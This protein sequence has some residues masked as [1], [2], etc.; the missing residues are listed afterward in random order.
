MS[1]QIATDS[2]QGPAKKNNGSNQ[3]DTEL[4]R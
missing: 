3:S 4:I 2:I 1:H